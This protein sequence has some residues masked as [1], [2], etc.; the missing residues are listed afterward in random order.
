[1]R[2]SASL[3]LAVLWSAV[4]AAPAWSLTPTPTERV[5]RPTRTPIQPPAIAADCNRDGVTSIDELQRCLSQFFGTPLDCTQ[6]DVDFGGAV[7]VGDLQ[8]GLNC[9]FSP[10]GEQCP[11]VEVFDGVCGDG[12]MLGSETCDD[13]NNYG[14][15]GCAANCTLESDVVLNLGDVATTNSGAVIQGASFA[16]DMSI[17]GSQVLTI[18]A[19]RKR[20]VQGADGMTNFYGGDLPFVG[21]T[22]KN[23]GRIDSIPVPGLVCACL[24]G[25]SLQACG[26]RPVYPGDRSQV[27]T[28]DVYENV[29]PSVCP[30]EDPCKPV[31]GPG[32]SLAGTIGCNGALD[33]SYSVTADSSNAAVSFARSGGEID[34][35]GAALTFIAL[36]LIGDDGTCSTDMNDARKGPDGIPCTD[37]DALEVQGMPEVSLLTTA[38]AQGTVLNALSQNGVDIA[39]G[40]DCG[41]HPCRT[42]AAG[43]PK[44]CDDLVAGDTAGI[45]VAGVFVLLSQPAAGDVVVPTHFC[46]IE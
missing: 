29:D 1:M 12:T 38:S 25:V 11:R 7:D 36:G 31:F 9:F 33:A 2:R 13:G 23:H 41:L 44:G 37:D 4:L 10:S 6:C 8:L 17:T 28:L 46:G 5:P 24:R 39:E 20:P 21:S 30:E 22:E 40:S 26:G 14:G 16:V 18:G 34:L 19:P 35:G 15:D 32:A 27:C 45:C 43:V 42:R 3:S